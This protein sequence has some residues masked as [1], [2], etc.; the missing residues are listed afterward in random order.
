MAPIFS[1]SLDS[2][3]RRNKRSSAP[4][5][6]LQ[7]RGL[8]AFS[9][10]LPEKAAFVTRTGA[11]ACLAAF[12]EMHFPRDRADW[13]P[14]QRAVSGADPLRFEANRANPYLRT[15]A[16]VFGAET[17]S[18]PYSEYSYHLAGQKWSEYGI[19]KVGAQLLSPIFRVMKSLITLFLVV[20][21]FVCAERG[22]EF[23][24]NDNTSFN[25]LEMIPGQQPSNRSLY[26]VGEIF[27]SQR[28]VYHGKS[29]QTSAIMGASLFWYPDIENSVQNRSWNDV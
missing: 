8:R 3:S 1:S 21:I 15:G 12:E 20:I 25:S 16:R 14:A 19:P 10:L 2:A 11:L 26:S 27:F 9:L 24:P 29:V 17:N 6:A 4:E 18:F 5:I 22:V 13:S 28:K 23:V 7:L